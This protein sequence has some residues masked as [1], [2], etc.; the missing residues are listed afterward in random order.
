MN[1]IPTSVSIYFPTLKNNAESSSECAGECSL[2]PTCIEEKNSFS[3]FIYT[4]N[5]C[6]NQEKYLN[7]HNILNS[8]ENMDISKPVSTNNSAYG[9]THVYATGI[10]LV[11]VVI[12]TVII[13]V[14]II[15]INVIIIIL[16][17]IVLKA[18]YLYFCLYCVD[19]IVLIFFCTYT[20]LYGN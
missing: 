5:V 3:L 13:V 12:I 15:I 17:F 8:D 20:C 6:A 9:I 11:I 4:T 7:K 1:F 16:M 10:Y 2:D 18:A 14:I 19:F